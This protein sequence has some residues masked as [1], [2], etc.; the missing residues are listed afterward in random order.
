MKPDCC[1]KRRLFL[2]GILNEGQGPVHQDARVVA[3]CVLR[4][5][6]TW[7]GKV[8]VPVSLAWLW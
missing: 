6:L 3:L 1:K 5:R 2:N 8:V 7:S 4:Y